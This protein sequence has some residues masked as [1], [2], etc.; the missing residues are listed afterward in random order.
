MIR[1]KILYVFSVLLISSGLVAQSNSIK[2][3]AVSVVGNS[4]A[5]ENIVKINSGLVD[6]ATLSADDIQDGIKKLWRLR[7]FSDIKVFAERETEEGLYIIIKVEE[8]PRLASIEYSGN[9]KIKTKHL[10]E[11]ITFIIGQVINPHVINKAVREIE[12]QYEE[13]G[14]YNV[15]I[16][17]STE[18][19]EIENTI[20]V[21]VDI[22]EGEKVRIRQILFEGNE[23]ISDFNLRRKMKEIK[24]RKW[25][26]F[27][28]NGKFD[29]DLFEDDKL[30]VLKHYRNSGY[31]DARILSEDVVLSEDKKSIYITIE[32]DEGSLYY[33]GD[34]TLEGNEIY[35]TSLLEFQLSAAGISRGSAFK[36]EDFELGVD[37]RVRSMYLDNG[38]LYAQIIPELSPRNKDT[39]DVR[40]NIVE[41]D[42]VSIRHINLVGNTRTRDFVIRRELR[43][44]P[45]DVFDREAL[46]RSQSDIFRLNYFSDV[47]PDIVPVDDSHID[48]EISLVERSSDR[49]NVAM[50]YSELDGIIGSMGVD[51]ANFRGMGQRVSTEYRRG[52]S[53]EY[54]S[55][56]FTEPWL[57]GKPNLLGINL[58]YS[59]RGTSVNYYQPYDLGVKG[60]SL[61][62]GRRFR[63]PDSYFRGSWSLSFSEKSYTNIDTDE[64]GNYVDVFYYQNPQGFLITQGN[65]FTQIISRDN[66]NRPEFPT[67]GSSVSLSTKYSGGILGGQEDFIKNKFS[68]EWWT[69]ILPKLVVYQNFQSGLINVF[70][71]NSVVPYDE[72]FYMGGAGLISYTTSLRGYPDQSVGPW[73]SGY[74]LGGK[75]ILKYSMELRY[76]ITDNPTLYGFVF[77]ESGQ[78]WDDFNQINI[79]KMARSAGSG[80]RVFMPMIGLLGFDIGYGFDDI[81]GDDKA[82]GWE[83][84]FVFGMPF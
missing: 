13:K 1:K 19:G 32:I 42:K 46:I 14:Y 58:Y 64:D 10:E 36:E 43:I 6:G 69:P 59:T 22:E 51:I 38:Y 16:D 40:I 20:K 3:A 39:L 26:T 9:K 7:L 66:R 81:N 21:L 62:F 24:Q 12:D 33:F 65:S 25:Y 80:V 67:M 60:I 76:L 8:Y 83:T 68:L 53:Y 77:A 50:G 47:V 35:E 23:N 27:F 30:A 44:F 48:L 55:L 74:P 37:T 82:D 61:R 56:G 54:M 28:N 18:P 79:N 71:D 5:S 63:W 4:T 2:I 57:L 72:R 52:Q 75:G 73:R 34:I 11:D 15:E 41:N 45:G 70:S 29:E 84:H 17:V 31:R 49:A 78:V